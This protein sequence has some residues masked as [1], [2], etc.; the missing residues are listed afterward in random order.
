[1]LQWLLILHATE[2]VKKKN[3]DKFYQNGPT[4]VKFQKFHIFQILHVFFEQVTCDKGTRKRYI[5][6]S[7]SI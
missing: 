3:G 2:L 1:M 7:D 5:S 6:V 4:C